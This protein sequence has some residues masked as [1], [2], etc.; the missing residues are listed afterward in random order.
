V[1]LS[2]DDIA[3]IINLAHRYN[4]AVDNHDPQAWTETWTVDGELRSPFGDPKG[5]EELLEWVSQTVLS[6]AGSRHCSVNEVVQGE[7]DRATMCSYYFAQLYSV[8]CSTSIRKLTR[9]WFA[10]SAG[11]SS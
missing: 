2:T 11:S 5:R 3:E 4:Q 10:N 1:P 9:G 7:G 8:T 6:Q